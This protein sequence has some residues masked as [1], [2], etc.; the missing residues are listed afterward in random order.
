MAVNGHEIQ[1]GSKVLTG[2]ELNLNVSL[3]KRG[4][5][6]LRAALS[7]AKAYEK[8]ELRKLRE[9]VEEMGVPST[10]APQVLSDLV[11][12]NLVTSKAGKNGGFKLIRS[13]ES[14]S[15]LQ[16]I[17]AGEGPLRADYCALGEGPCHWGSL[18]PLHDYWSRAINQMK[19]EL[20]KV[21]LAQVAACDMALEEGKIVIPKDSHRLKAKNTSS[22]QI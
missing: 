15:L 4:D 18:C 10:Y 12:T 2:E 3:S 21:S 20:N 13:P 17:E 11:R 1:K 14:I 16:I 5:Y 22:V 7:L 9:I 8:G 6:V 19:L